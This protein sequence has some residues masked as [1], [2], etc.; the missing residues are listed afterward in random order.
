[1]QEHV[2]DIKWVADNPWQLAGKFRRNAVQLLL[3]IFGMDLQ[4]ESFYFPDVSCITLM[5]SGIR[6]GLYD[7]FLYCNLITVNDD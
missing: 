5:V 4:F 3:N 6:V 1:M 7:Y 2:R